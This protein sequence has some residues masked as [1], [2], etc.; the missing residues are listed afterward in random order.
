MLQSS[1]MIWSKIATGKSGHTSTT[2]YPLIGVLEVTSSFRRVFYQLQ[3]QTVSRKRNSFFK[4][5]V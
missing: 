5:I 3:S 1:A 2:A 4:K